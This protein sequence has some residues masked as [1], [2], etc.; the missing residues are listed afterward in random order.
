MNSFLLIFLAIPA[1]EIFFMIKVGGL[2]GALNTVFLIFFTAVLGIYFAR[3]QGVK[4]MKSGIIN[5]YQN[6]APIYEIISGA[7]I[8]IAAILLIV[9][10]FG[11]D[12]VGFL[13]LI[14][15]S[16]KIILK[17][18]FNKKTRANSEQ[19]KNILDGEIIEDKNKD[20]L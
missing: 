15:F 16:R 13:L 7:S 3:L 19:E 9:P 17:L 5:I 12:I 10:G 20:E 1:A 11:T 4:T 6:K 18:I 2:I 14:P 8:A